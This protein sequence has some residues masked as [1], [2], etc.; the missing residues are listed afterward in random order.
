MP[1]EWER[2]APRF[3][4]GLRILGY[5]IGSH[6]VADLLQHAADVRHALHLA[7]LTDDEALAVAF[8]FYLIWFDE[9]LRRAKIGAV[10]VSVG[11]ERW[12]IG[13]GEP[14]ASVT[15]ER[16]ELF[17][18]LGGRRNAAQIRALPWEGDLTAVFPF[19]SAYP[20]PTEPIVET[21]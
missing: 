6:Y 18:M 3:E 7:P 12:T 5:E 16:F 19:L 4:E 15:G 1:R 10:V 20:L 14:I 17:R 11:D 13:D 21:T 8:D 9:T 2:E